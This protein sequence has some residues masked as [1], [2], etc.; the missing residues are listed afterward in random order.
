MCTLCAQADL[1]L[2]GAEDLVD[3]RERLTGPRG[4]GDQHLP[5]SVRDRLLNGGVCFDLVGS[6]PPV[7]VR[8]AAE[9]RTGNSARWAWCAN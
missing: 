3:D 4:H 1:R 8:S 7:I 5:L 2:H 9:P 6:Q